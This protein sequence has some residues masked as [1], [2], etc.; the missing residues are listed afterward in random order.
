MPGA[1]GALCASTTDNTQ[2][3]AQVTNHQSRVCS[4]YLHSTCGTPDPLADSE[5]QRVCEPCVNSTTRKASGTPAAGLPASKRHC[6]DGAGKGKGKATEATRTSGESLDGEPAGP[7]RR[8]ARG[9]DTRVRLSYE[10]KAEALGLLNTMTGTAVAA[11]LG[12]GVSS[13]YKWR[14]EKDRI[15]EKLECT[16]PGAKSAKGADFPEVC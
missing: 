4:L 2:A 7:I 1:A 9:A 10:K 14:R 12:V 13:V 8:K 15:R 11:K 6:E 16:K 3:P 5:M